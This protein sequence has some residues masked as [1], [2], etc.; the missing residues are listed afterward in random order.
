MKFWI[1]SQYSGPYLLI[2]KSIFKCN[3]PGIVVT[4]R[5]ALCVSILWLL[6]VPVWKKKSDGESGCCYP[7]PFLRDPLP[8]GLFQ[9]DGTWA[10]LLPE[11]GV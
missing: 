7:L 3:R 2:I 11:N 10:K 6:P 9:L 1:V 8:S 4:A 5:P